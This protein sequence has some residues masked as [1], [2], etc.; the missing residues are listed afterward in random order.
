MRADVEC[1]SSLTITAFVYTIAIFAVRPLPLQDV[2]AVVLPELIR[3]EVERV[4]DV[5]LQQT[6]CDK[7]IVEIRIDDEAT[8]RRPALCSISHQGII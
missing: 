8:Q 6:A 7:V 4:V 5:V 3:Y 1:V 2:C